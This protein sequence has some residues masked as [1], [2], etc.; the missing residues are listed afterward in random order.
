MDV[1]LIQMMQ[2]S[3][4]MK[5]YGFKEA[6]HFHECGYKFRSVARCSLSRKEIR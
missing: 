4:F 1:S 5:K 6:A 2:V 3:L